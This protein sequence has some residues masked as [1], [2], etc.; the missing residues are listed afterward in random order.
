M[1]P[2]VEV[3]SWVGALCLFGMYYLTSSGKE[4]QVLPGHGCGLLGNLIYI[5][6]GLNSGVY[7]MCAMGLVF[8]IL[9]VKG[10]YKWRRYARHLDG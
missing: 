7:A 10:I 2:A 5:V 3:L 6:V 9:N 1:H 4:W 8:S